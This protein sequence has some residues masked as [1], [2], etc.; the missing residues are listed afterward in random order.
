MTDLSSVQ[1][2]SNTGPGGITQNSDVP[3][4]RPRTESTESDSQQSNSRALAFTAKFNDT[5]RETGLRIVRREEL[6]AIESADIPA[7]L[8]IRR[9]QAAA[10][11]LISLQEVQDDSD[12]PVVRGAESIPQDDSNAPTVRGAESNQIESVQIDT[13]DN[14]GSTTSLEVEAPKTDRADV[15]NNPPNIEITL[16]DGTVTVG[17]TGGPPRGAVLDIIV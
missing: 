17:G 3:G 7:L 4:K 5:D 2:L 8:D 1:A 15:S 11:V 12:A 6:A 10:Q 9:S 13:S 14:G 16:P